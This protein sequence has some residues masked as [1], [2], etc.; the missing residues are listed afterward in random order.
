ML[1]S[2]DAVAAANAQIVH[3][4]HGFAISGVIGELNRAGGDATMAVN[5]FLINGLNNWL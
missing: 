1:T 2:V 4:P 3:H 5:A